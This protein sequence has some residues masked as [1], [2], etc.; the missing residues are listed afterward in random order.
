MFALLFSDNVTVYAL[1]K[2]LTL[3]I[4]KHASLTF[5]E[6]ANILFHT[7]WNSI[8]HCPHYSTLPTLFH[9]AYSTLHCIFSIFASHANME[10]YDSQIVFGVFCVTAM[11]LPYISLNFLFN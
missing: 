4:M 11:L 8:P 9:T 6:K 1:L 3:V 5:C 2:C 7:A 10:K